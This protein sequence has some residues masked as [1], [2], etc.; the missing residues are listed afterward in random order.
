M[1]EQSPSIVET[2]LKKIEESKAG[3]KPIKIFFGSRDDRQRMIAWWCTAAFG[4]EHASSK[5]QRGLRFLEEALELY[6]VVMHDLGMAAGAKM[7]RLAHKM[8]DYVLDRPPGNLERD[9]GGVGIT[10]SALAEACMVSA[11]T[12]EHQELE[13]VLRKPPAYFYARNQAKNDAGFDVT[14]LDHEPDYVG[15]LLPCPFCGSDHIDPEGWLGG[16]VGQGPRKGPVCDDCGASADSVTGWNR[17]FVPAPPIT[18]F[19]GDPS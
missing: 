18:I 8:V 12:C 10:L 6:Q 3:N 11:D 17:R 14:Q 16:D 1:T 13:R 15:E 19:T 4:A 7:R 9:F 2:T 5:P